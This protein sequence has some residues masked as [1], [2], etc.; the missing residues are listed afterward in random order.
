VLVGVEYR[1]EIT[2]E[3]VITNCYGFLSDD[4]ATLI[5][6]YPIADEEASTL[7][8]SELAPNL[9]A[10]KKKSTSDNNVAVSAEQ[11]H[12]SFNEYDASSRASDRDVQTET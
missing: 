3:A 8:C 6:E 1:R 2:D 12:F 4:F 10:S 9:T 5:Y 11:W 7:R